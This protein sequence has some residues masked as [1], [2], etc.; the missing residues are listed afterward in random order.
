MVRKTVLLVAAFFALA[1]H[2][3]LSRAQ[4]TITSVTW[5]TDVTPHR[6]VITGSAFGT[7]PNYGGDE[8]FLNRAWRNFAGESTL[9][10]NAVI[11]GWVN[12]MTSEQRANFTLNADAR[13]PGSVVARKQY[14]T[15]DWSGSDEYGYFS[16]PPPATAPADW[17]LAWW[18]RINAPSQGGKIMRLGTSGPNFWFATGG[19]SHPDTDMNF[20]GVSEDCTG[21]SPYP[22]TKWGSVPGFPIWSWYP[23]LQNRSRAFFSGL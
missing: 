16:V 22:E 21:C 17:Y 10:S 3:S 2:P 4:S 23:A 13:Y 7:R 9:T 18:L 11:G 1:G 15:S 5:Q 12:D 8:P 6:L 20:R 19:G 14:P